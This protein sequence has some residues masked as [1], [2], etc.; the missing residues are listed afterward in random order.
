MTDIVDLGFRV[1]S[2]ELLT[3]EKRLD[4]LDTA[5]GKVEGRTGKLSTGFRTLGA[6]AAGAAGALG[7][8]AI[9]S[10]TSGY[11]D[12]LGEVST[13]VDTATFDMDRLSDAVLRQTQE[14]GTLPTDGAKA[15]YQAISAGAGTVTEATEAMDAA[16]KLAIGGVTGVLTAV[17]GLTSSMNAYGG[18]AGSFT[19]ISDAMFVA[20]K[21][22]KT[23]IGE[24]SGS[25]GKL[26]PI[27]ATAGVSL[28][29]VLAATGALT[30]GGVATSTSM[31]G[32]RAIIAATIKPSEEAAKMAGGLGLEFNAAALES[33]GLAGFLSSV[34]EKTGG[35]TEKMAKLF[36]GVEALTPVLALTGA[37]AED[38]ADILG[39]MADKSGATQEA[40]DKMVN[41]PGFQWARIKGSFSA[42]FTDMTKQIVEGSVPAIKS[43]ADYIPV[44]FAGINSA[45]DSVKTNWGDFKSLFTISVDEN[46]FSKL[47]TVFTKIG[48]AVRDIGGFLSPI[49]P[50]LDDFAI[51]FVSVG[52][53]AVA[54]GLVAGALGAIAAVVLSQ[55]TLAIAAVAGGALLI[56]NNWDSIT[57]WWSGLWEGLDGDIVGFSTRF[58]D[59][60][61][62]LASNF[63][64]AALDMVTGFV[65]SLSE[66]IAGSMGSISWPSATDILRSAAIL[67]GGFGQL[68]LT[69]ITTLATTLGNGARAAFESITW[70]TSAQLLQGAASLATAFGDLAGNL[71]ASL[72]RGLSSGSGDMLSSITWPTIGQ[73]SRAAVSLVKGFGDLAAVVIGGLKSGLTT[74]IGR[75]FDG[76]Q[77]PT[78]SAIL[79]SASSMIGAFGDLALTAGRVLLSN[80]SS[81]VSSLAS[82]IEWPTPSDIGR[83]AARLV[84]GFGS[85][86]VDAISALM[87]GFKKLSASDIE[88][89]TAAEI[90]RS[91]FDFIKAFGFAAID[92]VAEFVKTIGEELSTS[93]I[94]WPTFAQILAGAK[95]LLDAYKQLA[96]EIVTAMVSGLADLG[97]AL[98]N[99]FIESFSFLPGVGRD[100]ERESEEIGGYIGEG[101]ERGMLSWIGNLF[102]AG[103]DL[104][105]AVI[106]GVKTPLEIQSPSKL[107]E[108]LGGYVTEGLSNGITGGAAA[109]AEA[110]R[111]IAE[112]VESS[113]SRMAETIKAQY[114][115]LTEGE[116]AA[117][118]YELSLR[119][120]T[121]AAQ[122]DIV[123]GEA[124]IDSLKEQKEFRDKLEGGITQS[125]VNA[126]NA[127]EAFSNLGDFM[128]DWLKQKIAEFAAS[129]IMVFLGMG[130]G[131]FTSGLSGILSSA[132]SVL[133]GFGSGLSGTLQTMGNSVSSFLGVAS[134]YAGSMTA[135]Q[136]AT[137]GATS[138]L[139]TLGA[140]IGSVLG[141]VGIIAG[142]LTGVHALGEKFA[143]ITNLAN[144]SGAGI[145]AILGGPIG[146][147]IG[148][149]LPTGWQTASSGVSV[150]VTDGQFEGQDYEHL[151]ARGGFSG[152]KNIHRYSELDAQVF[153]S[154]N[155]YF[156]NLNDTIVDQANSLGVS[157]ADSILDGFNMATQIFTGGT[158]NEDL[159]LWLENS[160]REAYAQ[161]FD[162]MSPELAAYMHG[163]VDVVNDSVEDIAA[164]V[165]TI[166]Q[167]FSTVSD[168]TQLLGLNFDKTSPSAI[169]ASNALVELMGG[170]DAFQS[171]TQSYYN[172]YYSLEDRQKIALAEAAI[173]VSAFNNTLNASGIMS[174][175]T[176]DQMMQLVEGLDLNTSAGRALW[177]Q[178]MAVSGSFAQVA[179]SGMSVN[180]IIGQLPDNLQTSFSAMQNAANDASNTMGVSA[181]NIAGAA[182]NA[183]NSMGGFAQS[184]ANVG[185]V[186]EHQMSAVSAITAQMGVSQAQALAQL[187]TLASMGS[188]VVQLLDNGQTI[189]S[190]GVLVDG[191]HAMGLDNVSR[192]GYIAELH[193]GEMVSTPSVSA[194][195]RAL[196]ITSNSVPSNLGARAS[197]A[198]AFTAPIT[199]ARS[200]NTDS[201][202]V[203]EL[204][205]V[206]AGQK[207][208]LEDN[209]REAERNNRA[210]AAQVAALSDIAEESKRQAAD[211]R[212]IRE[213]NKR[214]VRKIENLV[215]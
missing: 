64:R 102:S 118:R 166:S 122:D 195:L 6:A 165:A 186:A 69:A 76:F 107:M 71:Y 98:K 65:S 211:L 40:F 68:G 176:R 197:N 9:I 209:R 1:D 127:R 12:A 205:A 182:W 54:L 55:V 148:G 37:S 42:G 115:G 152:T 213:S 31:D 87:G 29:E 21:A 192:D 141:P 111:R 190:S 34:A 86:A 100:I 139:G 43:L 164:T 30:K 4:A 132:G 161:A 194:Q 53:S 183:S 210:A 169:G 138:A 199:S 191:S 143:Q 46:G 128:K 162:N 137:M 124:L 92:A 72:A 77:W 173:E 200:Q 144:E 50:H 146:A 70:P 32:L 84:L 33:Q 35:S 15:F 99:K 123:A 95:S 85:L 158:A 74:G 81:S 56:R 147:L 207:A 27:A 149:S 36:G 150:G 203:A 121:G 83:G 90:I 2:G 206:V 120:I 180:D 44:A 23:T 13:L 171:A 112:Q 119:G 97:P 73:I 67:V 212:E 19:D 116:E 25:I 179:D 7:L 154:V 20:V 187:Q 185:A 48:D 135:A 93:E 145:G 45:I 109:V 79:G 140:K 201:A 157:G 184:I 101:A 22:G 75:V 63:G 114:I 38:F 133:G 89:P 196:G 172:E 106:D 175:T 156:T 163:A 51:A 202:A 26:A 8:G 61:G 91:A 103:E 160:T 58:V 129:K 82:S 159:Q 167:S 16:N 62:G 177:E 126:S 94:K 178:A 28:D 104:A 168:A 110:A 39:D 11:I 49:I 108:R 174:I 188:G 193:K 153:E 80:I 24:L 155:G 215:A 66:G 78:A 125:I 14:Y 204:R 214:L 113:V 131:G 170:L 47:P 105:G 18:E 88:W 134:P 3:A 60:I 96:G 136:G 181:S 10:S 57:A 17:D 41:S 59:S 5:G 189:N 151:R 208:A 52:G 117:R 130:D 198:P 142:A